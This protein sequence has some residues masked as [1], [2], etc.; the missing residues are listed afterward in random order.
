MKKLLA[1]LLAVIMVLGLVACAA[2]SDTTAT[3]SSAA[4]TAAQPSTD[5]A[6]ASAD[7]AAA[8]DADAADAFDP[9]QHTLTMATILT[10]H[11]VLRIVELGFAEACEDLGYEYQIVGTETQD[12]NDMCAAAEAASAAGSTGCLLWAGDSTCFPCIKTLKNDYGTVVGV[13]HVKYEQT[14]IPELDINMACISSTYAQAVCEFMAEKLEGKTGSIQITQASYVE[15]EV[16]AAEAFKAKFEE[17]QAAGKFQGVTLLEPAIE[18]ASDITESTNVNVSLLQ[19]HPDI[20]ATFGL[21]GNSPVTW[22]NAAKKCGYNAGDIVIVGMDY[23]ADNLK[24]LDEGW[25]SCL[26]GQPLYDEAYQTVVYIDKVLRG[27]SVDYWTELDA[28]LIFK[29]GE[30]AHDPATYTGILDRVS[31]KFG[32]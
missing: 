32:D 30:G 10:N 8:G 4:D 29:G 18:G 9:S 22:T 3:D 2:Q 19:A 26:V 25:V 20:I 21:T 5:A 13:P 24:N 11:P 12:N 28:P 14:D 15:N 23:T 7:T 17:L 6:D 31:T 16:A 27:E 1:L